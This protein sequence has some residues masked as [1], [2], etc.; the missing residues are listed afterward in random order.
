MWLR[1]YIGNVARFGWRFAVQKNVDN[2]KYQHWMSEKWPKLEVIPRNTVVTMY[3][4]T[5]YMLLCLYIGNVATFTCPQYINHQI[6]K[7][8]S[9]KAIGYCILI[10]QNK[11]MM[12]PPNSEEFLSLKSSVLRTFL[13]WNK[14]SWDSSWEAL[15][16]H[17]RQHEMQM[18]LR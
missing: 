14:M 8:I 13:L 2:S 5:R 7:T 17:E 3:L 12:A 15:P 10:Y 16:C 1:C 9:Q 4:G 18:T 6:C 11:Y